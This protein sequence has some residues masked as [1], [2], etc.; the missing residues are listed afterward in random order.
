MICVVT[1]ITLFFIVSTGLFICQTVNSF[2]NKMWDKEE[3][4]LIAA[5]ETVMFAPM[6]CV[7][8]I[9]TRMRA[10]M[11]T[12]GRPEEYDLPQLWVKIAMQVCVWSTVAQ[13][14]LAL[15]CAAIYG[16]DWEDMA[17][18]TG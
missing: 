15:V 9:A 3:K 8:F 7:L 12:K 16:E 13:T 5:K 4:C 18:R 2:L 17:K 14:I 10:L 6:L 11:L 1:L